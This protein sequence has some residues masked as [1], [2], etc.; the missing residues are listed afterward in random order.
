MA[1]L[2]DRQFMFA[3]AAVVVGGGL[4]IYL[5][6]QAVSAAADTAGGILSGNNDLTRDTVYE[7]KGVLGTLGAAANTMSGGSLEKVGSAIGGWL[8]DRLN[9][10]PLNTIGNL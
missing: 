2:T 6:R 9:P 1:V 10:D 8:F 4:V 7:D 5:G 3:A